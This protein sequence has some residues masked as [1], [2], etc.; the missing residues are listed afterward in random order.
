VE[1]LPFFFHAKIRLFFFFP[2]VFEIF[3]EQS[4]P[5][6]LWF[7]PLWTVSRCMGGSCCGPWPNLVLETCSA[8]WVWQRG[9]KCAAVALAKE[10]RR[11]GLCMACTWRV[12]GEG[13][14]SMPGWRFLAFGW[15]CWG[16]DGAAQFWSG[17]QDGLLFSRFMHWSQAHLTRLMKG[18]SS[19]SCFAVLQ[20]I[21]S[22]RQGS[23]WWQREITQWGLTPTSTA[24][25]KSAWVF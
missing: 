8:H 3:L 2:P 20:I 22:T 18:V 11:G 1:N 4:L 7:S 12:L 19:C 24:M 15:L 14:V 6:E 23:N 17:A 21:L 13:A 25:G 9:E 16:F 5:A 10:G